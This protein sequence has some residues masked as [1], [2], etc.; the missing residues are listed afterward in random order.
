MRH[1]L[2]PVL[3]CFGLDLGMSWRQSSLKV[4]L[5]HLWGS[6]RKLH[7][8]LRLVQGAQPYRRPGDVLQ[9]VAHRVPADGEPGI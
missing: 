6:R 7:I 9:R 8:S 1:V 5:D 4:L 2:H 3:V